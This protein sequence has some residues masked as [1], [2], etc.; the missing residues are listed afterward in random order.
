MDDVPVD[1]ADH[2]A[3]LDHFLDTHHDWHMWR[4]WSDDLAY[5]THKSQT[6]RIE[7][8]HSAPARET[9][10]TVAA[11]E[12]PVSDRTWHLTATGATP[13]PMLQDLLIDLADGTAWDTA[14]GQFID[15]ASVIAATQPA[16]DAGWTH[17]FAGRWIHWT[18]PN[19][20]A[21]IQFDAFAAQRLNDTLPTWV[22]WAGPTIDQPTWEITASTRTPSNLLANLT[23]TLTQTCSTHQ[24]TTHPSPYAQRHTT[25]L[26]APPAFGQPYGQAL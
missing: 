21:G 4:T 7:R 24:A 5:A 1:A 18:A 10:W 16:T 17:T 14:I 9:A 20:E 8:D 11:Y 23:E 15:E 3:L 12:T 26:P 22:L 19:G 6:L 25:S 2:D 13:L